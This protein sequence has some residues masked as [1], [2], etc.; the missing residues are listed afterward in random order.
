MGGRGVLEAGERSG[1]READAADE[2]VKGEIGASEP[3]VPDPRPEGQ[4]GQGVGVGEDWVC[5]KE[6]AC[7]GRRAWLPRRLN[8]RVN[9]IR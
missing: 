6:N 1:I 4:V 5:L 8:L 9:E 3:A 7:V 2:R